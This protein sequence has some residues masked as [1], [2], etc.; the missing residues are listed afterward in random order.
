M[1][2]ELLKKGK[3]RLK[4]KTKDVK[5]D[6]NIRDKFTVPNPKA[7]HSQY[8]SPTSSPITPLGSFKA[9]LYQEVIDYV[10]DTYQNYVD[11]DTSTVHDIVKPFSI[12]LDEL[13]DLPNP[14][15]EDRDYQNDAVKLALEN[16]R[17]TFEMATSAGK[18]YVI[19]KIIYNIWKE[20]AKDRVIIIV[21]TL[22]L[23]TQFYDDILDYGISEDD[24]CMFA[25]F[26]KKTK[27]A[28][29]ANIIIS[30]ISWLNHHEDELPDDI[31]I[32]IVDEAHVLKRDNKVCKMVEK[33]PLVRF[34]FTG[35]LP[36]DPMDRWNV[37]GVCGPLLK[38][39]KAS[40]LQ[41]KGY[42]ANIN[43][44]AIELDHKV[45]QPR[46]S[47]QEVLQEHPEYRTRQDKIALEIAKARFPLEWR[48]IEGSDPANTFLCRL[49]MKLKGNTIMLFDHTAHGELLRDVLLA[50]AQVPVYFINGDVKIDDREDIRASVE[51]GSGCI[52]VANC[53]AFG[54]GTNIKS[55]NNIIF[56]FSA[57]NTATKVIQ[58]IGRGLRM[59]AG[60]TSM[61]LYDVY[62]AFRYSRDHFN[63]RKDMYADNYTIGTFKK[64]SVSLKGNRP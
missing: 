15:F 26:N 9:G 45:P 16:G 19:T 37:I 58:G 63:N 42:I 12:K 7:R 56:A 13:H 64:V 28:P 51:D 38:V 5:L 35:T 59:K 62:H 11:I 60:K 4:L 1:K 22:Q 23:V 2:L 43:I 3:N 18:S 14:D 20:R 36:E 61:T 53:K 48:F 21:P 49:A 46:K 41:D 29:T 10:K 44:M 24:V 34:G 25:S 40:D 57:G 6:N 50:Q 39:I 17:G 55:I 54:T 31:K 8:A 33:L 27:Q 52:L 30:N 32:T 47:A